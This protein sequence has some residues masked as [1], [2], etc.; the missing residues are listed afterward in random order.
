MSEYE[1][2]LEMNKTYEALKAQQPQLKAKL[3]ALIDFNKAKMQQIIQSEPRKYYGN[4]RV[5]TASTVHM[6]EQNM[7]H[8]HP[9]SKYLGQQRQM[10]AQ[11][12]RQ[13]E[14]QMNKEANLIKNIQSQTKADLVPNDSPK[15]MLHNFQKV[16]A[17]LRPGNLGDINRVV[18]P[19]FFT[20]TKTTLVPNST[21]QG[22]VGITQEAA[23]IWLSYT[24][25]VFLQVGAP[26]NFEYIDPEQPDG[27]GKANNLTVSIRESSSSRT[28]MNKS[29][30]VNQI[31]TWRQPTVLPTPQLLLPNSN[32]EFQFSNSDPNNT[33]RPFITLYG[34]RVRI[35]E[36]QEILS[37][38]NA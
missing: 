38:V 3:Q 26:G 15:G 13:L 14:A 37:T 11:N 29:V 22:N 21:A 16:V 36:A 23:F 10:L 27:S 34:L 20:T 35:E 17:H 5:P 28:F 24:K 2:Y 1:K 4:E 8:S 7:S 31:G 9:V 25:A 12:L 6:G 19:F 33:Y 32:L 18:W 30:D